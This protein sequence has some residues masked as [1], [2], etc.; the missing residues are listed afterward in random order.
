MSADSTTLIGTQR[1]TT[2]NLWV[3]PEGKAELARRITSSDKAFDGLDGGGGVVD[4]R[5]LYDSSSGGSTIIDPLSKASVTLLLGPYTYYIKQ[6][7]LETNF[8]IFGSGSGPQIPGTSPIAGPTLLQSANASCSAIVLTTGSQ[9]TNCTTAGQTG[10]AV[11]NVTLEGFRLYGANPTGSG[12]QNGIDIH[13]GANGGGLFYSK[14]YDL[15]I[16]YFKCTSINLD[17]SALGTGNTTGINQFLSFRDI[18]VYRP[19]QDNA[20]TGYGLQILGAAGQLLFENCE[21]DGGSSTAAYGTNIYI[22]GT[23]LSANQLTFD[24]EF[25]KLTSQNAAIG[26]DIAGAYSVHF[27]NGHFEN[28][29]SAVFQLD[30]VSSWGVEDLGIVIEGSYL[31]NAGHDLLVNAGNAKAV[32][33]NNLIYATPTGA[34]ISNPGGGEVCTVNNVSPNVSVPVS[35]CSQ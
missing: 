19:T 3:A 30:Y 6:I 2:S 10:V 7:R 4:A 14:F 17:G 25:L 22:A 29:T 9:N 18:V 34:A 11:Q 23:N 24:A 20:N 13:S 1:E 16:D 21:F 8:R 5:N 26:V 28:L 32:F 27:L 33:A 35:L 31:G 15:Y 12:C